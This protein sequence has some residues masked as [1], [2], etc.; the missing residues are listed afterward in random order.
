LMPQ[1]IWQRP[2]PE[3]SIENDA[4][5]ENLVKFASVYALA[6][7]LAGDKRL[8]FRECGRWLRSQNWLRKDQKE[9]AKQATITL[10]CQ[11]PELLGFFLMFWQLMIQTYPHD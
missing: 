1:I 9:A 3:I 4:L 11:A 7:R 5:A 10:I 6:A 2:W 8:D